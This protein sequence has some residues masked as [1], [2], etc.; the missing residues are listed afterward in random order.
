VKATTA[1][2]PACE[3]SNGSAVALSSCHW[4]MWLRELERFLGLWCYC[5]LR[6]GVPDV[7]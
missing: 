7:E 4:G 3:A 2:N 6:L 1:C 5:L